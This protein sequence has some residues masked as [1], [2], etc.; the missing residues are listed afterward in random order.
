MFEA[1]QE[2]GWRLV[3]VPRLLGSSGPRVVLVLPQCTGGPRPRPSHGFGPSPQKFALM[4]IFF[5][6]S[7]MIPIFLYVALPI[8][9]SFFP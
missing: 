7:V 9:P 4:S 6:S 5:L 3:G 1:R 2:R 8:F